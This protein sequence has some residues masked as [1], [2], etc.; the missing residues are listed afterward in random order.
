MAITEDDFVVEAVPG[1]HLA[2]LVV[3]AEQID[4]LRKLQLQAGEIKEGVQGV[5]ATVNVVPHEKETLRCIERLRT[6]R[7]FR[8]VDILFDRAESLSLF[9]EIEKVVQLAVDVAHDVD[10]GGQVQTI[11]LLVQHLHDTEQNA[12]NNILRNRT[13]VAPRNPRSDICVRRRVGQ[14]WR[15]HAV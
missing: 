6:E 5:I 7:V 3:P 4:T 2:A 15:R 11:V 9:K 12:S 14:I 13:T 8:V 1:R 10:R